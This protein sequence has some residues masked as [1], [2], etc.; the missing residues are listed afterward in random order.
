LAQ[1]VMEWLGA[2]G[3]GI[4]PS[5]RM[6]LVRPLDLTGMFKSQVFRDGKKLEEVAVGFYNRPLYQTTYLFSCVSYL[7][8]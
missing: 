4:Y 1:V 8:R 2:C 6:V 3:G 7:P 5:L